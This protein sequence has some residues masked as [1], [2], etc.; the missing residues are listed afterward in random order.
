MRLAPLIAAAVPQPEIEPDA[1]LDAV[2]A[3]TYRKVF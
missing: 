2:D 3:V 1:G